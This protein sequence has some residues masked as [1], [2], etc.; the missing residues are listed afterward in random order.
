MKLCDVELK[1][2]MRLERPRSP[3]P[4]V[5]HVIC[6]LIDKALFRF[7]FSEVHRESSCLAIFSGSG[8]M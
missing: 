4:H 2:T 3:Q 1:S 6:C 5:C 8:S 7:G